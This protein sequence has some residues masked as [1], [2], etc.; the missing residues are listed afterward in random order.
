MKSLKQDQYRYPRRR[1]IRWILRVLANIAIFLLIDLKIEGKENIPKK[2]PF[3]VI[4]NHFS[5][6]DPVL[7]MAKIPFWTEFIGGTVNPGSP[8]V[9]QFLPK[10]WGILNVYRGSSSRDALKGAQK[11]LN[12]N[13][14]LCIFPEGGNWANVLRPARPGTA[15][16]AKRMQVPILPIGFTGLEFVF[17]RV[18]LFKRAP[19]TMKFGPM[20]G[21]LGKDIVGRASREQFDE[22]GHQL[23]R[24]IAPLIPPEQHGCY[25]DDPA[26]REAALGTEVWPW[27]DKREGEVAKFAKIKEK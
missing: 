23:M 1:F 13:G 10:L 17:E 22:M 14:V 24:Q 21:P 5:F 15:F 2:G 8:D 3:I 20:F 25:S 4:G 18:K 26:I 7:V 6:I 27:E 12:Q 19:V 16:L 9:V 11:V